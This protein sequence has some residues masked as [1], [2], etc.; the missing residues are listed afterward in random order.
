MLGRGDNHEQ[1]WGKSSNGQTE[2]IIKTNAF[3]SFNRYNSHKRQRL[4]TTPLWQS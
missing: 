3:I 2:N 4:E 1:V